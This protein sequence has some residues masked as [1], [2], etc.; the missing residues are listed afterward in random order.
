MLNQ[1]VLLSDSKKQGF[2]EIISTT[3]NN[4]YLNGAALTLVPP[5]LPSAQRAPA[6]RASHL[7][8]VGRGGDHVGRASTADAARRAERLPCCVLVP[9]P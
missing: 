6:E 3:S 9:L 5:S 4:P 2:L 8:D 1:P 7:G